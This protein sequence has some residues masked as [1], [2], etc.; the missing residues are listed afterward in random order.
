MRNSKTQAESSKATA[1]KSAKAKGTDGQTP[2]AK[3]AKKINV[4]K[5]TPVKHKKP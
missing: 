5:D 1:P 2:S 3:D 4:T